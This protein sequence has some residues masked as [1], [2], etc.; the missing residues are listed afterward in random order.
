V[1][2]HTEREETPTE[3]ADRN[4]NELL[5]ELR[6]TQTG[7]AILFSML[8]TVPFSA[9]FDELDPF[10]RRVYLAALLLAA[11]SVVSLI[12]PVAYHRLLFRQGE[13][14]NVVAVSHRMAQAGLALLALAVAAV[15]LLVC[16][17]LLDRGPAL[18]VAVVFGLGTA[19]LWALPALRR[20]SDGGSG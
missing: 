18:A 14:L 19:G 13:K 1:S 7:V 12:G 16:D 20:R 10:G 9:R 15:L 11:A 3:R 2:Q 8:L 4:W 6:V 17:L 5:Q